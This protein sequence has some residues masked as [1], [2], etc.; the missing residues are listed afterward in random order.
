MR[1]HSSPRLS[2]T[3]PLQAF[4]IATGLQG[5]SYGSGGQYTASDCGDQGTLADKTHQLSSREALV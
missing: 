5:R 2:V 4:D 1:I 3:Q